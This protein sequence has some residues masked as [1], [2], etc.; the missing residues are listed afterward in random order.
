MISVDEFLEEVGR[1]ECIRVWA[2]TCLSL[3]LRGN[4]D[5]GFLCK[6]VRAHRTRV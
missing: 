2:F 6:N 3:L 4:R 5:R 1:T